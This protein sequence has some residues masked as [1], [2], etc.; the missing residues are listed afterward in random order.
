VAAEWLA[1]PGWERTNRRTEHMTILAMTGVTALVRG[2]AFKMETQGI[3]YPARDILPTLQGAHILH[4]S[5]EIAFAEDCP[6]PDPMSTSLLF[7]SRDSYFDL[8]THI[9]VDVVELTGNHVNDWGAD[10]F[11]RT[12]DMYDAANMAT[13]GGG[14]E[15]ESARKP[16]V[17]QH[18]GNSLAF[19]GC[20]QFGPPGSYATASRAGSAPCDY[21]LMEAQIAE[22]KA[23]GHV[24]IATFQYAESYQYAP[25]AAQ[26]ADF[27][28][29]SRA[30]A[31]I[32]SGSQAHQPQG[33]GF[34]DKRLIHF[35]VGN[36]FFDQMWSLGTRQMFVDFHVI[37]EGRHISTALWT[38]LI[39]DYARPREMTDA[40]RASLL[41]TVFRASGW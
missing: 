26:K 18:N 17:L 15:I 9:G 28:R 27:E 36:L 12:L 13:F 37:Y 5:N 14:R 23:A 34:V 24:V 4:V 10:N 35:G 20:N 1:L 2:T 6:Y 21:A 32:V 8:L 40:E 33:F 11:V 29:M 38:G 41:D 19:T 30:G 3:T 39:E 7:C 16:A 31:D 22:L 25:T